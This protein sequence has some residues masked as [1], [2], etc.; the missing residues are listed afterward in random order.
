MDTVRVFDEDL[1]TEIVARFNTNRIGNTDI[2]VLWEGNLSGNNASIEYNQEAGELVMRFENAMI[3]G[4]HMYY[5][6]GNEESHIMLR[7][8]CLEGA[9]TAAQPVFSFDVHENADRSGIYAAGQTYVLGQ[10]WGD[11]ESSGEWVTL[12]I[13]DAASKLRIVRAIGSITE[14]FIQEIGA[15]RQSDDAEKLENYDW[16]LFAHNKHPTPSERAVHLQEPQVSADVVMMNR[17]HDM[18]PD[19]IPTLELY[20]LA[21]GYAV[22]HRGDDS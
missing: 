7:A 14:Q 9:R 17:Y 8:T 2:A 19:L 21:R 1:L 12:R 16:R 20:T 4:D 6:V 5:I 13:R 11:I 18:S 3:L 10:P 15:V 22:M